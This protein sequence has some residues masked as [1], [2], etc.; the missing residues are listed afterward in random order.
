M[1]RRKILI[2][3]MVASVIAT[4]AV[5]GCGSSTK[6]SGTSS[7]SS[8]G[9]ASAMS[10]SDV[11]AK[12]KQASAGI[13][14]VSFAG[15]LTVAVQAD[16][17][18]V[19]DPTTKSLTAA[20]VKIHAEGSIGKPSDADLTASLSAGGQ[21]L[22]MGVKATGSKVWV[23]FADKWYLV[24]PSQAKKVTGATGGSPDAALS[25]LGIDP[26]AWVGEQNVTTETLNGA[27][28]YHV[29]V[30]A[31]PQK[32]MQD[33]TKA[34]GA[35]GSVSGQSATSL[36]MLKGLMD[37]VSITSAQTDYW[38]DAQT[39]YIVKGSMTG[40]MAF[41]GTLSGQGLQ[42]ADV[43]ITF[44]A[45][46]FNQPVSVTPPSSALPFKQLQQGLGQLIPS[47]TGL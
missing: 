25:K 31:D 21:N 7:G 11:M 27:S 10:A 5:A 17:A 24:P 2:V 29:V 16:Q 38:I 46:K 41:S 9:S 39:F 6:S 23:E 33:L 14:S 35:S 1:R 45:D 4:L 32:L 37:G 44:T 30:K 8:G 47:G 22:T 12:A 42:G 28:V 43:T 3:V 13:T 34:L 20:P 15:D 19:T 18:K 36:N 26:T 40:K